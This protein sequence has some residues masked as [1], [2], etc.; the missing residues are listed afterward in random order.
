M[1]K[2]RNRIVVWAKRV[3]GFF[4]GFF[5]KLFNV[6]FGLINQSALGHLAFDTEVNF[7]EGIVS[8]KKKKDLWFLSG[9]SVNHTL[10]NFWMSKLKASDSPT[11][12]RF[13]SAIQPLARFSD[14]IINR[15]LGAGAGSILDETPI[16]FRFTEPQVKNANLLL[17]RINLE[18][19][20][21]LILFCLRDDAYYRHRGDSKNL[22][23]H[24]HRNVNAHNYS[25]A[26]EFF[27]SKNCTVIRMGRV[28]DSELN[29]KHK[30][31]IDLPFD[32]EL[33]VEQIGIERRELLEL[34]LFQRCRFVFSTGLGLDSIGTL[35]RKRV[36]W[37]D[38]YSVFNIYA[39]ELFPLF[40]PK[41]YESIREG[42]L[43][44]HEEVFSS[45]FLKAQT[46]A[47]FEAHGV[48]LVNCTGQQILEF[49]MDIFGLEFLGHKRFHSKLSIEHKLLLSKYGFLDKPIPQ[50]SQHWIN[51]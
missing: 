10:T 19:S 11:R 16:T 23:T 26:I 12:L 30:D 32:Q 48:R 37:I 41:G 22:L 15:E 13:Y 39:S 27:L 40:L 29:I 42:R 3:L 5:A 49:A 24:S 31:F 1:I 2:Y 33:G 50:I 35:F 25:Q 18:T 36:Y 20:K 6:R 28:A 43:F 8:G 46:A 4:L 44:T 9:K 45:S 34:A 17:D 51:N 38:Y 47:E 14:V 21:P 7:L